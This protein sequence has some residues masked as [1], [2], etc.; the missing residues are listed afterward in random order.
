MWG[1][2]VQGPCFGNGVSPRGGVGGEKDETTKKK[3]RGREKRKRLTG[4]RVK[5]K[6]ETENLLSAKKNTI[7]RVF[8]EK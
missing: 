2:L 6:L 3:N 4:T 1:K 7:F 5:G 8:G